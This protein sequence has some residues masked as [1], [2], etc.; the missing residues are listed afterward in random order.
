MIKRIQIGTFDS[1]W[2][3]NP[4]ERKKTR[5]TLSSLALSSDAQKFAPAWG[6]IPTDYIDIST[7]ATEVH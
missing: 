2:A 3:Y 4:S 7:V 1:G 6:D 5:E